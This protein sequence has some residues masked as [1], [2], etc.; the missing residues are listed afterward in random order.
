MK[1]RKKRRRQQADKQIFW[2]DAVERY[3]TNAQVS[4]VCGAF[5]DLLVFKR[6]G[7]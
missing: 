4:D 6:V 1:V 3:Q 5:M 2:K 7:V